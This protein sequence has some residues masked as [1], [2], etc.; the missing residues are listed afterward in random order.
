[1][2]ACKEA[3]SLLSCTLLDSVE[4]LLKDAYSLK[5]IG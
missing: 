1:M 3:G 4:E 2:V 5:D